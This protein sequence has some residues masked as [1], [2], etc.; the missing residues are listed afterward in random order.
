MKK[1]YRSTTD[2]MIAGVCG[3]LAEYVNVDPTI[4]RLA[5]AFLTCA[6]AI[7]PGVAVYFLAMI[8]VPEKPNAP[9]S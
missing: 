2:R 9:L 6:T 7:V 3:G 8:I 5:V 1:L 4:I